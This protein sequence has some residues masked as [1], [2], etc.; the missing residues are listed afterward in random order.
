MNQAAVCIVDVP[1]NDGAL[2][3]QFGTGEKSRRKIAW[4]LVS[5]CVSGEHLC[6]SSWV[7]PVSDMQF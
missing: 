4:L 6:M 3:L 1:G 5:I 2:M 7:T